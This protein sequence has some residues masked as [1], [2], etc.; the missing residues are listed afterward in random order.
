MTTPL[1]SRFLGH[2]LILL[3][4]FVWGI[5]FVSTKILVVAGLGPMEIALYRFIIAY[6]LLWFMFPKFIKTTIKEELFFFFSGF[7]G[8]TLY[9]LFE[10]NALVFTTAS[11]ASFIVSTAPLL[12]AVIAHFVTN[13]KIG[14]HFVAGFFLSAAGMFLIIFNGKFVLNLNPLGDLLAFLSA[15]SWA[16]YSILIKSTES[17]YNLFYINRKIF[18]YGLLTILP[19]VIFTEKKLSLHLLYEPVILG[20]ILFL[21]IVASALCYVLWQKAVVLI[22]VIKTNNYIYLIPVV[23]A[24]FSIVILG[25]RLTLLMTCGAILIIAG[26]IV[27]NDKTTAG[28]AAYL[29]KIIKLR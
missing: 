7:S 9:F 24:L 1:V 22:G 21:G 3:T 12:T 29:N 26:L 10:N 11:N 16:V 6:I 17:K 25:E 4:V 5:T 23:T 2:I 20:N 14:K 18:F 19:F 8:V 15:L 13:E 27:S 28:I